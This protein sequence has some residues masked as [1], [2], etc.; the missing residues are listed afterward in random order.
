[1]IPE[2]EQSSFELKGKTFDAFFI[3][4]HLSKGAHKVH[5]CGNNREVSDISVSSLVPS[6]NKPLND[7]QGEFALSIYVMGEYLDR[8]VDDYRNQF[9]I[10]KSQND[11]HLHSNIS[12]QE[13]NDGVTSIIKARF[14]EDILGF[15]KERNEEIKSYIFGNSRFEYMH[16]L[17]FES[18]LESIPAGLSDKEKDYHLHRVNYELEVSHK[19]KVNEFIINGSGQILND[20]DRYKVFFEELINYE[21]ASGKSKLA[22]YMLHRKAVLRIF[23]Q[24]IKAKQDGTFALE[25]EIHNIIFRKGKTNNE[26]RF[27]DHNLWLLDERVAFHKYI[28]SDKGFSE[29]Y[30]INSE[31]GKAPDLLVY[32]NR[33]AYGNNEDILIFFEFKRPMRDYFTKEE[34]DLG[35]QIRDMVDD[36]LNSRKT[37]YNGRP[38]K[39]TNNTPKF[40]YIICDYHHSKGHEEY[41]QRWYKTSPKGTLYVYED[42]INLHIELLT[43]DQ[44][45]QDANL[46]HQAFF[47]ELGL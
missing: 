30:I 4:N 5:Y 28:T 43:Y 2:D 16:L 23:E 34:K 24:F 36:L 27:N 18:S 17:E 33:F 7:E 37:D 8:N 11:N 46:R 12:M 3:H 44:L 19:A 29:M 13:I 9:H 41:L 25:E 26:V 1:M 35:N 32:D 14:N 31:S 15:A 38:I 45:L 21:N 47:S 20:Y 6:F 42:T 10:P 39:I 40:G 22:N